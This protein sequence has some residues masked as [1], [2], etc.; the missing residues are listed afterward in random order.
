MRDSGLS[1]ERALENLNVHAAEGRLDANMAWAYE[2]CHDKKRS[3][4]RLVPRTYHHW[5]KLGEGG[6]LAPKIS[7]EDLS[8]PPWGA[9]LLRHYRQPQKPT[10]REAVAGAV[11]EWTAEG[12]A[13]FSYDQAW[14]L[15]EK[16]RKY[17]PEV[18]Y[19]G[20]SQ[21]AGLKALLPYVKRGTDDLRSNDVWT[22]DGHGLKAAIAH[23][24]HGRPFRPEVTVIL[25]VAS[26]CI[27][28]WSVAYAENVIAVSDALRHAVSR[29][30]LPL[31]YYS[32]N[33]AGQTA[34]VLDAP[35]GGMSARLGIRHE[36]GIPGNP[37]G[38]GVIERLW[39]T[40]TIPL[41]RQFP[42]FAGSGAD[43]DFLR[44]TGKQIEKDLRRAGSSDKLPKIDAFLP[45]LDA[46]IHWYNHEHP[47]RALGGLTPA[48]A[49]ADKLREEDRVL[50]DA[51]ELD[52]LFRPHVER[53]AQR[54]MVTLWNNIYA[55]R[56]LMAVD[57]QKVLVGYDIHDPTY[58]VIQRPSGEFVCRAEFNGNEKRFFPTSLTE[59]LRYQRVDRNI[60]KKEAEID[61]A[62]A[63]LPG[64]T[65]IDGELVDWR[66]AIPAPEPAP[67]PTPTPEPAPAA[68]DVMAAAR[69]GV[70][71]DF[72][73]D[74]YLFNK[75]E[76]ERRQREEAPPED[77]VAAR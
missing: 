57:G 17:A 34:K 48:Q 16:I 77:E 54:G 53:T 66:D 18:L 40:L 63:E 65:P 3:G 14:R 41:A 70:Y 49:Y 7:G 58:V 20:R 26:R 5:R 13:K 1:I 19:R 67:E 59:E 39:Q 10:L 51:A 52:H 69:T 11:A 68:P 60:K 45:A 33:G 43:R 29:H 23:P 42:T 75:A 47:H 30:G 35:V 22:G 61:L 71:D 50:L 44:Q 32:D 76:R 12:N 62:R 73:M 36:T 37:Q 46:A 28:G 56:E 27:V 9:L 72:K 31:I 6:A 64:V 25:D 55:S 2:N 4:Q 15:T 8:M 74:M 21:G 24:D 38:R